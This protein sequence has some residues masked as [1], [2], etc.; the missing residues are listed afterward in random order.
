MS[1]GNWI[2]WEGGK[3]PVPA[4]AQ[5]A[6]RLRGCGDRDDITLRAGDL[7]WAH[8]THGAFPGRGDI[9]AYRLA[10]PADAARQQ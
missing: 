7:V 3:C 9:L 1:E 8:R 4:D 6:V 10:T 5:V 2:K